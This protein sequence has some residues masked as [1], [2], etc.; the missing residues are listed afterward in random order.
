MEYKKNMTSKKITIVQI[1]DTHA[2]LD[3][4]QEM[5]WEWDRAVYRP[6]GGYARIAT[7]LKEIRV[8]NKGNVLFCDC[9]DTLH[10]TYVAI[11]TQGKALIPILNSLNIAAM[12]AQQ[13]CANENS[14]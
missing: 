9:G 3:L 14:L 12:T 2:Y 13:L 5:F 7:I 10:G 11:K 4:H 6:V 1:N 8:E